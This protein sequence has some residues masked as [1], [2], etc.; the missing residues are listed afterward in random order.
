MIQNVLANYMVTTPDWLFWLFIA[1]VV[2]VVLG[3]IIFNKKVREFTDKHDIE[4]DDVDSMVRMLASLAIRIYVLKKGVEETEKV[5]RIKNIALMID[6]LYPNKSSIRLSN[7]VTELEIALGR[8]FSGDELIE[9]KRT[10]VGL[11][12]SIVTELLPVGKHIRDNENDPIV[13]P[14]DISAWINKGVSA[15][16]YVSK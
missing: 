15:V 2:V 8:K 10:V 16:D 6:M 4:Y 14:H 1:V 3:F 12:Q 11:Q 7:L 9:H 13:N 5:S